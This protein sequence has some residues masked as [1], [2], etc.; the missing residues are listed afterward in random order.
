MTTYFEMTFCQTKWQSI[1]ICLVFLWNTGL[2][3]IW[4]VAWLLQHNFI[5]LRFLNFNSWTS[6][7]ILI[8]SQVVVTIVQCSA[9][10]LECGMTFCCFTLPRN[11]TTNKHTISIGRP[12]INGGAYLIC[13]MIADYMIVPFIFICQYLSRSFLNRY[14]NPHY[15][16][17]MIH[18]RRLCK[19]NHY[20]NYEGN[21]F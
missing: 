17:L 2:E 6:C 14:Q 11:I 13:I 19:L 5:F 1:S 18:I 16:I 12:S 20:S 4:R 10:T 21:I 8:N 15:C 9:S 3:V 7:L